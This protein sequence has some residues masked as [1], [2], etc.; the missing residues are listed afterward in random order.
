MIAKERQ[1]A[2]F[3]EIVTQKENIVVSLEEGGRTCL[4]H[5][6]GML[7]TLA[8]LLAEGPCRTLLSQKNVTSPQ[9]LCCLTRRKE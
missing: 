2:L 9:S 5:A 4:L 7:N 6:A 1:D 8:M 3:P